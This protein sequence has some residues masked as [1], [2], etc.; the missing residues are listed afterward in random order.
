MKEEVIKF[1]EFFK[2]KYPLEI[3]DTFLNG[4][5]YYFAIMLKERFGGCIFYNPD[6]VHFSVLID[7]YLYDIT[8]IINAENATWY[9]WEGYKQSEDTSVIQDCCINKIDV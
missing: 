6:I 5:C 3:T 2:R 1:I 7:G 8:G 4:F 9:E